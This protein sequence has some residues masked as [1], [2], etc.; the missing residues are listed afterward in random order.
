MGGEGKRV[1][2]ARGWEVKVLDIT[3]FSFAM[4]KRGSGEKE[5]ATMGENER[6]NLIVEPLACVLVARAAANRASDLTYTLYPAPTALL[7]H[8]LSSAR[9]TSDLGYVPSERRIN[10][11]SAAGPHR[12]HL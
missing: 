8:P 3:V 11:C 6:E 4:R 7:P 1:S 10:S 12:M 9:A 2:R 5:E